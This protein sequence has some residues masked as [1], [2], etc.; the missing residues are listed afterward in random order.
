MRKLIAVFL[1]SMNFFYL[2]AAN[3][4]VSSFMQSGAFSGDKV[5][6]FSALF[7]VV[8]EN[9]MENLYT[10]AQLSG[11]AVGKEAA[12]KNTKEKKENEA[13]KAPFGII[14]SAGFNLDSKNLA[15]F[16]NPH[17]QQAYAQA[18]ANCVIAINFLNFL[19]F[20]CVFLHLFRLKLFYIHARSAIDHIINNAIVALKNP[21]LKFQA[22]FFYCPVNPNPIAKFGFNAVIG[23]PFF[24]TST[25]H[26]LPVIPEIRNR[27]S[28]KTFYKNSDPRL[29][30]SGMTNWVQTII[31]IPFQKI[32][33]ITFNNL[34]N[35]FQEIG[36]IVSQNLCNR[37]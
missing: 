3:L 1:L 28:K 5:I 37:L 35:L 15:K 23:F 27:E 30:H 6:T 22:G 31:S 26:T 12:K 10:L 24:T 20:L 4:P 25:N 34:C 18:F 33:V 9:T 21:A 17:P 8:C 16:S 32:R 36:V 19:L 29:R 13:Q 11:I 7:S 2:A 14:P